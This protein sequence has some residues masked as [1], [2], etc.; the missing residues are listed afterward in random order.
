[1]VVA[2]VL[3]HKISVMSAVQEA[4][5]LTVDL[6]VRV[7]PAKEM[8]AVALVLEEMLFLVVAEAVQELRDLLV[9]V[10]MEVKVE[11]A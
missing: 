7:F 2:K 9:Q 5:V 6:Q 1:M 4:V 11:P 3:A 10:V 8:E